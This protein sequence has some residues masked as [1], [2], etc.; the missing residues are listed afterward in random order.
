MKHLKS[1]KLFEKLEIN[2]ISEILKRDCSEF[3][4]LLKQWVIM[5]H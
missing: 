2:E 1:F 4:N 3:L 5:I